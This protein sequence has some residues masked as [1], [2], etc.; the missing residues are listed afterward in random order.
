[1]HYEFTDET[2]KA[3]DGEILRRIRATETGGHSHRGNFGGFVGENV[4]LEKDAWVGGEARVYGYARLEKGA[5]VSGI[6]E[7]SGD[8]TLGRWSAVMGSSKVRG[9]AILAPDSWV[10]GASIIEGQ[11]DARG[12]VLYNA[13]IDGKSD[14]FQL[15]GIGSEGVD[16]LAYRTRSGYHFEVGCWEGKVEDLMAEVDRRCKYWGATLEEHKMWYEQYLGI[17]KIVKARV[18][19]WESKK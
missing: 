14:I 10:T 17:E 4:Y 1:M 19:L 7:V 3:P 5:R 18:E 6:A 15:P 13:L 16:V 8:A 9:E 11:A 2:V 12:L